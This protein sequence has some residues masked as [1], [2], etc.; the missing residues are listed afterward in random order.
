MPFAARAC[1]FF[2]FASGLLCLGGPHAT[3]AQ[4]VD[5]K[6]PKVIVLELV[7]EEAKE[8]SSVE[9]DGKDKDKLKE[10]K[11]KKSEHKR[12]QNEGDGERVKD[13]E[14]KKAPQKKKSKDRAP[15]RG[16]VAAEELRQLEL[17]NRE[18]AERLEKTQDQLEE[19][20]RQFE[21]LRVA[22][23]EREKA[24]VVLKKELAT[25]T[26]LLKAEP[27]PVDKALAV[28]VE[29]LEVEIKKLMAAMKQPPVQLK[30]TVKSV[31]KLDPKKQTDAKD[32]DGGTLILGG[33]AVLQRS[34]TGKVTQLEGEEKKAA[35]EQAKTRAMASSS[36]GNDT[37]PPTPKA[38]ESV[39]R[40]PMPSLSVSPEAPKA[41]L[42][43]PEAIGGVGVVEGDVVAL[44]P[45]EGKVV[46]KVSTWNDGKQLRADWVGQQ[47]SIAQGGL[48]AVKVGDHISLDARIDAQKGFIWGGKVFNS[49][50]AK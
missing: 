31:E 10:T 2:I 15:E 35:I 16:Q 37:P 38:E 17:K 45:Q 46:I 47:V 18:L 26:Q 22:L 5:E 36:H 43:S 50:A 42:S 4:V 24:V 12:N 14:P 49:A 6:E 29:R 34:T 32:S 20:S 3:G 44:L 8:S 13:K 1:P 21:K 39:I 30:P 40:P 11:K 23:A 27:R 28:R 25:Q 33:T 48:P 9:D 41:A 7:A 19:R